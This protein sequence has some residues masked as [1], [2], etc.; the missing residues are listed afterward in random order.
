MAQSTKGFLDA[1]ANYLG[2]VSSLSMTKGTNLFA[3]NNIED[4]DIMT[5]QFVLFDEGV[6]Q[7]T[8][9]NHIHVNWTIRIVTARKNRLDATAALSPVYDHLLN[10]KRFTATSDLGETFTVLTSRSVDAPDMMDKLD[11]G[12][13]SAN[14]SVQFEL[15]PD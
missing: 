1:F 8:E 6:E 13:Y 3:E 10:T 2:S 15:I 11:S 4:P 7:L 5:N 12:F 14:C 9:Y